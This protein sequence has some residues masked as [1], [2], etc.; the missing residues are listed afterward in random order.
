MPLK[1]TPPT[2]PLPIDSIVQTLPPI[3]PMS[4]LPPAF[5]IAVLPT[6]TLIPWKPPV[7]VARPVPRSTMTASDD[8][9]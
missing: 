2:D 7:P 4:V 6:T 5:P 3:G 9:L 8:A 1:T